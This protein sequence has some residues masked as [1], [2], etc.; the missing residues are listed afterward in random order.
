MPYPPG[1]G[2]GNGGGC[3]P[4]TYSTW[5]RGQPPP[6]HG[7]TDL[8]RV[9]RAEPWPCS[10]ANDATTLAGTRDARLLA[11]KLAN[12]RVTAAKFAHSCALSQLVRRSPRIAHASSR[13]L[14]ARR[15]P[16]SR[17]TAGWAVEGVRHHQLRGSIRRV[18][19]SP[20]RPK[21]H[22]LLTHSCAA[23]T[24]Q[25]SGGGARRQYCSGGCAASFSLI[26]Q[27]SSSAS[28]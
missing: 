9:V 7:G 16:A 24:S 5:Q 26:R 25:P 8:R 2:R 11:A 20:D 14:A 13:L 1:A 23:R 17:L 3:P 10:I 15:A 21:R 12:R 28:N 4:L 6:H 18:P 27:S 19:R 22:R